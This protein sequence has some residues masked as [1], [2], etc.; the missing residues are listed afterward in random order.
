MIAAT[1]PGELA[2][3]G[4]FSQAVAN[5]LAGIASGTI[6]LYPNEYVPFSDVVEQVRREVTR[7]GGSSQTVTARRSTAVRSRRSS[8]IPAARPVGWCGSGRTFFT[9]FKGAPSARRA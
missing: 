6:D 1:G 7:L 2:Y 4:R 9:V 3:E 5:V 8:P